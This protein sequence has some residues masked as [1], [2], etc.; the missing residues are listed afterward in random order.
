MPP[1]RKKTPAVVVGTVSTRSTRRE[2]IV[3]IE[4]PK[5]NKSKTSIKKSKNVIKT[6]ERKKLSSPDRKKA[7]PEIL[8]ILK[9]WSDEET[10]DEKIISLKQT[11][12]NT[13]A[14]ISNVLSGD[15][16]SLIDILE[17]NQTDTVAPI[18]TDNKPIIEEDSELVNSQILNV[19]SPSETEVIE[20]CVVED[21]GIILELSVDQIKTDTKKEIIGFSEECSADAENKIE[22][23]FTDD[24][25]KSMSSEDTSQSMVTVKDDDII[26]ELSETHIPKET[27]SSEEYSADADSE[28]QKSESRIEYIFTD[29]ENK[30]VSSNS[31]TVKNEDIILELSEDQIKTGKPKETSFSEQ[32]SPNTDSASQKSENRIEYFFT[33]D[34]NKSSSEDTSQSMVTVKDDGIILELANQIKA[35][36][37]KETIIVSE[38]CST[39]ADL[40]SQKS[41]NKIEYV[42]LNYSDL[43][44]VEESVTSFVTGTD[45]ENNSISSKGVTVKDDLSDRIVPDNSINNFEIAAE[46]VVY[47]G[48][49]VDEYKIPTKEFVESSLPST[50]ASPNL[51]SISNVAEDEYEK[52]GDVI[53]KSNG[54]SQIVSNKHIDNETM[55]IES[56]EK[57]PSE[58]SHQAGDSSRSNDETIESSAS[59][60]PPSQIKSNE[61]ELF[62]NTC[63]STDENASHLIVASKDECETLESILCD[64]VTESMKISNK[65]ATS[66]IPDL[67]SEKL[68]DTMAKMH[69][70]E[71]KDSRNQNSALIKDCDLSKEREIKESEND[72]SPSKNDTLKT[73]LKGK[74]NKRSSEKPT[75]KSTRNKSLNNLDTNEGSLQSKAAIAPNKDNTNVTSENTERKKSD[76]AEHTL[77]DISLFGSLEYDITKE[78]E[79]DPNKKTTK[80]GK[81]KAKRNSRKSKDADSQGS[82][83]MEVVE[84]NQAVEKSTNDTNKSKKVRSP[85]SNSS[86][87][88]TDAPIDNSEN[89][90]IAETE[91]SLEISLQKASSKSQ[92]KTP[93]K[94][95]LPKEVK[96]KDQKK[97]NSKQK[98][99]RKSDASEE[100]RRSD[101]IKTI[102]PIKKRSRGL[103]R[104]KSESTLFDPDT[105]DTSSVQS[106]FEKCTPNSS[107][108]IVKKDKYKSKSKSVENV[109][110]SRSSSPHTESFPQMPKADGVKTDKSGQEE[111]AARLK[112]FAHLKENQY[113][114]DRQI[115][116][117]AQEM[118]CD[119]Y[120]AEE[121]IQKNEFG[122]GEDCLNRLLLIECG[123]LCQVGDRCTNK[124][125]QKGQF[126]PV[127][128]FKTE[129]KGLGLRAAANIPYGEFI[130]E[131]IGEVLDPHEF[132]KR[133]E[134]Y[135][136]DKNIHFYFM[137]LRSDAIIDATMRGNISR[138]INHSCDPNAETQKWTVNGELR[139]GFFSTRTI[140]AGEEIT[141]DY[142]FQRYGKEAQKCYCE[143]A[144]CRGWLG[145]RPVESEDEE[146]EEEEEDLPKPPSAV[147]VKP[148]PVAGEIETTDE[149]AV[150]KPAEVDIKTED[151][152]E[153]A[154]KEE[155]SVDLLPTPKKIVRKKARKEVLY[156]DF[157]QLIEDI[158]M[159][160]TTGLKNQA[161]TLKLSRLMVR[162]KDLEQRKKLLRVLRRGELPCRRLFLDYHGLRFMHGYMID[163]Q[164]Q[165][166]P[167]PS[168]LLQTKLELLQ[169]L[170]VLPIQN[171]TMLI[172]SKVLPAVEK[173]SKNEDL[174]E[175]GGSNDVVMKEKQEGKVEG[176][177]PLV[178][179]KIEE[180][181]FLA[182]KLLEEWRNLK[183][184]FRI[185]KKQRIE[186]MKEHEKEANR[187]F[188]A[189]TYA[190]EQET[191]R[192]TDQ[193]R[194]RSWSR[195]KIER[196]T[197]KKGSKYD[198]KD[199][200]S[201]AFLKISK[202][203]R[204]KLFALQMELKEE[205]RRM[206][207]REMW[208]QHE[209][210]CMMIGADPRFTA[211]FDP[212]KGFQYIWNPSIGQWQALPVP[213][214]QNQGVFNSPVTSQGVGGFTVP[215]SLPSH[216]SSYMNPYQPPNL[217]V[218]GLSGSTQQYPTIQSNITTLVPGLPGSIPVP[219]LTSSVPGITQPPLPSLPPMYQEVKEEDPSQVK[220]AGPI[221]PPA[222]LPP[223]WK[224]AKDKYGRP[225]YYHIKIRKSQ[226]EPPPLPEPVEESSESS[227]SD[228]SS[229]SSS[230]S[231][232][233]SD[234][235]DEI[236]DAKL[237]ME[238]RKQMD[239]IP[240]G[241]VKSVIPDRLKREG[242][243]SA[244]PS[245]EIKVESDN[246]EATEQSKK[247][248]EENLEPLSSIDIRL[249]EQFNLDDPEPP[250]KKKRLGLCE[251][252]II[253]PRTEE[254]RLQFKEDIKRYKATKEKLKRQK[255]QMAHQVKKKV[256]LI[257]DDEPKKSKEKKYAKS[258]AKS[259]IR[260]MKDWNNESAKKIKEIF[261][262]S[263]AT[264]VV[265]VL[266]AYRKPD[267]KEGR[268]VNTEDFKHL[269]RKLTHFVM[270][271]EI[272]HIDKIEDLECTDNVKTKA[273]EYIRKYMSKFGEFYQKRQDEPD[274]K[275]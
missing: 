235:E 182:S 229:L 158:E 7:S 127:E 51:D 108:Q 230:D 249:K 37:P 266:N 268:I 121:D 244:T 115:C 81:G 18:L 62:E 180:I 262:S 270:L 155:V 225:Y 94:P 91:N 19:E 183:E 85:T 142:R 221:P 24:E 247:E 194:Y 252:I 87:M 105:S 154:K 6:P 232:S 110:V 237:L 8:E 17:G 93:K 124:R 42:S 134:V 175:E 152:P 170:A 166:C 263:M 256:K 30:S 69:I 56:D 260:E 39:D 31:V 162:A 204:R 35:D 227:S 168:A 66:K 255:E 5:T 157:D 213:S 33:E 99:D 53:E 54:F 153:D 130:L 242:K 212:S 197:T 226:W 164:Q 177:D 144:T 133:A 184:S 117:E 198:D 228:T 84:S 195:Y 238:V 186:Q 176:M 200:P 146:E 208:R 11:E 259:R 218:A 188:M 102:I 156:E 38:E 100:V 216:K 98:K 112:T 206:K 13:A 126:A 95:A 236:D 86:D 203:E 251:E 219:G 77:K 67:V 29:D 261:R 48:V 172:E 274:F 36:T 40:K 90:S 243:D 78:M 269:A 187:K 239:K 107:P 163:A 25:N 45:D 245:P 224:C 103:V 241:S 52:N 179:E 169:T 174:I 111:I 214:I 55:L 27:I 106:E 233:D 118:A 139:I 250:K 2:S 129:K 83:P 267:C 57:T 143:A 149:L 136:K 141:F 26:L 68:G 75:R 47:D 215:S 151:L 193:Q 201:A 159:L 43:N 88:D 240:R 199:K 61:K 128:V 58:I 113:K 253:S 119:C 234:T 190:Q 20:E 178:A 148:T 123:L 210:N 12:K 150:E 41:E 272:K 125:F 79:G 80:G 220:F 222:K 114:T 76:V 189:S 246:E 171:K 167:D 96:T 21:D 64:R 120:L 254:D 265:S 72:L 101:R 264:T 207:Q 138:F 217:N 191:S 9:D 275:D 92:K 122:C 15:H 71:D 145:E 22:Y 140:L 131:Y 97:K 63:V 14:K 135:S 209:L 34:E 16:Q 165:T 132:D 181:K 231:S 70:Q 202:H 89:A 185:P 248:P 161:H 59:G 147:E 50:S 65:D 223:K 60:T 46:Q 73:T 192:K 137:S 74:Y 104:S 49:E 44:N 10:K 32:C 23:I 3:N 109:S 205:E 173:W 258:S 4:I 28:S 273:R 1:K 196:E 211:P 116:K 271:K 257:I 82:S 160:V